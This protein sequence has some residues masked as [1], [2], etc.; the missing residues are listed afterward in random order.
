MLF[1]IKAEYKK[2]ELAYYVKVTVSIP[3]KA[4]MERVR[5]SMIDQPSSSVACQIIMYHKGV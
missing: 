1:F 4:G 2:E 3:A 5:F